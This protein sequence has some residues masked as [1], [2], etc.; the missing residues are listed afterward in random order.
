LERHQNP[1][2]MPL[3]KTAVAFSTFFICLRTYTQ[4]D[5]PE[6][7]KFTTEEISLKQCSFD[8]EA[9]AIILLD[10]AVVNYDD[11]YHMITERR[12]RIKILNEKGID[13]ANIII[14]FY[15]KDD[16]EYISKVVAYTYNFDESG[17]QS[18]F[19]VE[20][21]SIY[22]EK[23]NNYY[24]LKKFAL[25]A[26]KAGSIIEYHYVSIMKHYGGLEEWKFQTD[27][28]TI[29]S[30]YL[31]QV[32]PRAE[33]AYTVQKTPLLRIQIKN[34][35]DQGR[36]YF[37]MTNVPALRIE[38]FMD[39]QH[40]YIQKVIFQLSG[41]VSVYGSKLS[42]N[43]TW[44]SLAY[45]LMGDKQFGAQLDKDLKIEEIK[46]LTLPESSQQGKL[47]VIYEF[48]KK[49]IAW[50][51]YDGKFAP[52]GLKA[53]WDRKKGSAGEMNLLLI[54]LLKSAHIEVYPVL[55]AERDF[56]KID[57]TY[58][59][60]ER[61][62][63]T[64]GFA[65]ADGRQY[66]LDATQENCPA[67]LTP[68]PLLGTKAFLVDK[69]IFNIIKISPGTSYYKNV[70][71]VK[72]T[73]DAK[74]LITAEATVKSYDYARQ[75]R[76]DAV[77]RD[78]RRFINENFE[79]PYEG[80]GIDS[81]L[82]VPPETDSTPLE[83]NV[84]YKQQLNESGGFIFLNANLFTGLEK[85]PFSSSV[86]FTNV[87]FGFPYNVTV[88]EKIKLP[89]GVKVELPEDQILV[90]KDNNIQAVRQ[91]SLEAGEL[92]VLIRFVQTTTLVTANAYN[93]MKGFYKNMT[94]MLNEPIV[95]KLPN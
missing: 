53:V 75:I 79:K 86:R 10:K 49:N 31:L 33:F 46:G 37:E 80:L 22:T 51:G 21:N 48:V 40:D 41:Y 57:T 55:V 69:K 32:I 58:P 76:L 2:I 3:L 28:P 12:V 91:V 38:P 11:D 61:F 14:P 56:G 43:N 15:H 82:V 45:E 78:K 23:R 94:D 71:A 16:F 19:M 66:I 95:L 90:S 65:I 13:R 8:P 64:V 5:F 74:G 42:V 9:E 17:R 27:L 7:G 68:F 1:A 29:Q 25:P 77:K 88:E 20:K 35:S 24:S 60:I 50:N 36:V 89:E 85:N 47:R 67:G 83:Q 54:N 81:F 73:M 6:F 84:R 34:M 44:K 4:T 30:S 70:I 62:N 59:Y 52:D 92:K 87:N 93:E 72:G 63:K 39:A 18:T 26:V